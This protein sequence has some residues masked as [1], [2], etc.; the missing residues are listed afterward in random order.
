MFRNT[1][2][3]LS[4]F[5]DRQAHLVS[6]E[7]APRTDET[8]TKIKWLVGQLKKLAD[9]KIL[10]ICQSREL[11]ERA[12]ELLQGE[13]NVKAAVFHEGLTLL[14]RDRNAAY[15]SEE[16]GARILICSEIGS[17]GRNFQFAHHLVLFDLPTDP[18]LL[19]QRIGRLDRI[20]Q[21]ATIHVHVPYF[22]GTASEVL[23][24]WYDDGLN[25]FAEN[26][27]G[28]TEIAHELK[29]DLDA[30]LQ[31]FD[32]ARLDRFI[33]DSRALRA[34]VVKKL[35]RGHD[36]LLALASC[37]PERAAALI[38]QIRALDADASF[39]EFFLRL[40]DHFGVHAEDL[41]NRA[42]LFLPGHLLTD[43]FP[44]LPAEGLPATFERPR[45]LSREDLGF[46]TWDH[47]L[48]R[49]ALDL[50][51]GSETGN[52]AFGIWK[53]PGGEAIFLEICAV[54]EAVAP[55]NLHVDRFLPATP[56]RI[57][58]DHGLN[59]WSD[60]AELANAVL[61][62]GDIFRL[63]DRGVVRKKLLPAMLEKTKAIAAEKMQ[64]VVD[65]A[66]IEMEGQLRQEIA[67]LE[68]LREFN[69]HVR[70]EEIEALKQHLAALRGVLGE[71]RV[72]VDAVRLIFRVS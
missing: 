47:P 50:L 38:E 36:R 52:S 49:G 69:D 66:K 51:L 17:E 45:A 68:D 18:E 2:A 67:R 33:A 27:H 28:A 61:E 21:T 37:R 43:A 32:A 20:G 41:G 14:Q 10:L 8:T 54:V 31:K 53:N 59:E 29:A 55:A 26:L 16:D 9:E 1:R 39:E 11:A 48:V 3:A 60:N 64:S 5:P 71:A 46:L 6:L 40:L 24:R 62:K 30:L 65:A 23:A 42:H 22:P 15:F 25:A 12:F 70:P 72:R 56:L 13:M 7:Q 34:K 63:L 44:S 4:G 19:E 57:V 35:E 58:V